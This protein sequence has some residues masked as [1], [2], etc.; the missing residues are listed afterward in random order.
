VSERT[1]NLAAAAV[2]AGSL[3][4]IGAALASSPPSAADRVQHLASILKCPVCTSE[5]IASSPSGIAREALVLIEERVD[6][7][8]TDEEIIDFFVATYGEEMLLDPPPGGRTVALWVLPILA[9]AAGIALIVTRRRRA[10]TPV[11]TEADHLRVA[12]ALRRREQP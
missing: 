4:V 12:E 5:S 9:A 11:V 10:P 7:G 6:E 3:A 2:I 1:R 8:W